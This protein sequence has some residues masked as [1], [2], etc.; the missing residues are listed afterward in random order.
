MRKLNILAN[1]LREICGLKGEGK[2]VSMVVHFPHK[3]S[4]VLV[5]V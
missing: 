3:P 4:V 5:L 2:V 1:V